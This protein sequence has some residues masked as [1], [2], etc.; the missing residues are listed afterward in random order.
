MGLGGE[1]IIKRVVRVEHSKRGYLSKDLKAMRMQVNVFQVQEEPLERQ[2]LA[3]A[4]R[5]V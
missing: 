3:L 2:V 5:P 1:S 4:Q